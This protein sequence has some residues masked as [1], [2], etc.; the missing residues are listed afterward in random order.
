MLLSVICD[1]H[2]KW[3]VCIFFL[4]CNVYAT[5]AV[6]LN[7]KVLMQLVLLLWQYC[8]S[9]YCSTDRLCSAKKSQ[10]E[11]QQ[12]KKVISSWLIRKKYLNGFCVCLFFF[13]NFLSFLKIMYS[14]GKWYKKGLD[15]LSGRRLWKQ[16]S[17]FVFFPYKCLV[18]FRPWTFLW[19]YLQ[20]G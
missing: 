2:Q 8:P 16:I 4:F 13:F 14:R 6:K 7:V 11:A 5:I 1:I 20:I 18:N 10:G 12:G 3:K 9:N 15:E 17:A 19:M